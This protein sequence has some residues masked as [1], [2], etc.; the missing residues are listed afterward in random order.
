MTV[1]TLRPDYSWPTLFAPAGTWPVVA[2]TAVQLTESS[3][4]WPLLDTVGNPVDF[5]VNRFPLGPGN[6][7]CERRADGAVWIT[8]QA[9]A[10]G[11]T[12]DIVRTVLPRIMIAVAGPFEGKVGPDFEWQEVSEA[13]L[14]AYIAELVG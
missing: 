10:G 3:R 9:A 13:D 12:L 6:V 7:V 2:T 4:G 8:S 11:A 1:P 5:V 14:G